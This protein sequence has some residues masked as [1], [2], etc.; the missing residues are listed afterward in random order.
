MDDTPQWWHNKYFLDCVTSVL[1]INIQLNLRSAT[2]TLDF[3]NRDKEFIINI[4]RF[5][6]EK[7][8]KTSSSV[9]SLF[10]NSKNK[11]HPK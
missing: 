5:S 9:Q 3:L 1:G 8:N 4:I 6:H 7:L 11:T 2:S 10:W